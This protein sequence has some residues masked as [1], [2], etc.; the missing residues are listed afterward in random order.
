M[1]P[2]LSQN[3]NLGQIRRTAGIVTQS[4][5]SKLSQDE[6]E[7]IDAI[8][9]QIVWRCRQKRHPAL[10]GEDCIFLRPPPPAL[11]WRRRRRSAGSEELARGVPRSSEHQ[12]C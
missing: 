11:S 5:W 3:L 12:G 1:S 8:S 2:E 9:W 4:E 7:A 6:Q 10:E